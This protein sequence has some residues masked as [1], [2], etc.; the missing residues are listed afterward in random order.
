MNTTETV[1]NT[2]L[3]SKYKPHYHYFMKFKN[4]ACP[5]HDNERLTY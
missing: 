4:I 5:K 2:E 1:I 3:K